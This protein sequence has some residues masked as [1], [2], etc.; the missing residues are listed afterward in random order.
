VPQGSDLDFPEAGHWMLRRDLNGLIDV[1]AI[2]E[3]ETRNPFLC[4]GEGAVGDEEPALA[5]ADGLGLADMG[6]RAQRDLLD[7]SISVAKVRMFY[8]SLPRHW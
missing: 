1:S 4:F 6:R 7:L 2:E 8:A 3:I 5:H